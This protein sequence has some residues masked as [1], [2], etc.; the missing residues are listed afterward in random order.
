[1]EKLKFI[2]LSIVVLA[3]LGL[4]G[5]WSFSTIQ[6]GSEFSSSQKIKQLQNENESLKKEVEILNK[7]L[8]ILKPKIDESAPS[9]EGDIVPPTTEQNPPPKPIV[10]KYQSLI[11]ELQ[12]L[13]DD[14][15]FMKLKSVGTRVG[16]L[17]NF[18]NIY[19]KTSNKV[20]NDYGVTMQKAVIAFQK[21]QGLSA[22]GEAGPSTFN[23]MIDWLKKQK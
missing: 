23:K 12:K 18:L 22:D 3:V 16:T 10:Y 7:E 6:S 5:Y 8:D 19:N 4:L 2:L 21:D 15:I 1:M 11:N 13:V 14:N 20:D 9:V 17:Q